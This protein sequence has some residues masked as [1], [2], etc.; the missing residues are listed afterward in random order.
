MTEYEIAN[1]TGQRH[2][3]QDKVL[4]QH[5]SQWDPWLVGRKR[6]QAGRVLLPKGANVYLYGHGYPLIPVITIPCTK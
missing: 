4:V 1:R 5:K 6:L 2:F 3:T